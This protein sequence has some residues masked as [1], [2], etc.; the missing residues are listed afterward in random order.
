MA[1]FQAL[2][3]EV[4][5]EELE[6]LRERLGLETSQKAELLREIAAISA[7]VLQQAARGRT[8]EARRG[9]QV[10]Q[11]HHPAV[12]RLVGAPHERWVLTPHEIARLAAILDAPAAITP[13]MRK[14]LANI[15]NPRRKT[16]KLKW[17]RTA[18]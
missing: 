6:R 15:A 1:R 3:N 7:W 14:T 16:P 2:T 4:L 5:D 8:I 17:K 12:Q 11:L 13:A 18:A 9:S 10:E